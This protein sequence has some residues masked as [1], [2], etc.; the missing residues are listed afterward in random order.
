MELCVELNLHPYIELKTSGY[1]KAEITS[2][3]QLVESCGLLD[4]CTWISFNSTY[5]GYVKAADP[6]ARLGYLRNDDATTTVINTAKG[7]RTDKNEV[8]LDLAYDKLTEAGLL[9]AEENSFA[10]EVW[11]V[12]DENTVKSLPASISGFTSNMLVAEE[13]LK[14]AQVTPPTCTKQGYTT[15][16]CECGESYVDDYVDATGEHTYENGICTVCGTEQSSPVVIT[17]QPTPDDA[18]IGEKATVFV[19]AE[20]EGLTYQWYYR[21]AGETE[22]IKSSVTKSNYTLTVKTTNAGRELYCV[23]TDLYGNQVTTE[24][25][26]LLVHLTEKLAIIQQPV[27]DNAAVGEKATVFVEATGEGLSYQWYYRDAGETEFTK[28][29]VTKSNYTLTVK[30]TNAD[31]E[32]YCVV[33]DLYGNRVTTETVRLLVPLTESLA[34]MKQPVPDDALIGEKATVYVEATGSGLTYQ[35]YYRDAGET[36]FTKST[37]TKSNYTLT[38]KELNLER[39][40][41][42]VITDAFG[43]Q[44]TTDTVRLLVPGNERLSIVTQPIPTRASIGEKATVSVVATGIGLNYQW[45]YRDAGQTEF[46]KSTVTKSVYTLTVKESNIDR[47]LYCVISDADG[48][49]ITTDLIRLLAPVEEPLAIITQPASTHAALG[50]KATVFV[51]ATGDG[52]TY[53]W[54]YRDACNVAFTKST[55]TTNVYTLTVKTSNVSREL[56]CV[57]TDGRGNKLVTDTVNLLLPLAEELA[58]VTQPVP[59]D[60]TVG[61]K[62]KIFVEARG[63]DLSYQWYYR[64]VGSNEFRKSTIVESSYV[65]TVKEANKGR[66]LYCVITDAH[67][68]KVQT[69]TIPL[70]QPGKLYYSSLSD[71]LNQTSGSIDSTDAV[72]EVASENGK[73]VITLLQNTVLTETLSITADLELNLNGYTVSSSV[74]PMICVESGYCTIRNGNITLTSDGTGTASAPA[75]AITVNSGATLDASKT[76]VT[77]TDAANST[78][79]GIAAEAD[80]TLI[81]TQTNVAVTTGKSL[82]NV[83]V[84]AKGTA[85]LTDCSVI[86]ESD[87]TGANGKYTSQSKGVFAEADLE[88]YNCYVWGA[89]SGVCALGNVY[90]DGGT[91]EGY[92]HGSFYFAGSNTTSYVYNAS[93]N[94][95]EMREGT[96][97]DTVAGTNGAGMY[98]GGGA[99]NVSIYMDNCQ[100]YGTLYGIVLRNSGGEKNNSIYISNSTFSGCQSY[101]YRNGHNANNG[102]LR[103]YAGVGNDY[104]AITGKISKFTNY[105]YETDESYAQI[106]AVKDASVMPSATVNIGDLVSYTLTI[107]NNGKQARTVAV[108]DVLPENSTYISGAVSVEGRSIQWNDVIIPAGESIAL[109]YTVQVNNDTS[110]YTEGLLSAESA[111]VD[112]VEVPSYPIYIRRTLTANDAQYLKQAMLALNDSGYTAQTLLKWIY[113]VAYSKSPLITEDPLSTLHTLYSQLD[114]TN[115]ALR[116]TVAPTLYG[117]TAVAD[118]ADSYFAGARATNVRVEDFITGDVL[119]CE[120]DNTGRIYLY[121]EGFVEL[122]NGM[123][124]VDTNSVLE[125]ANSS[126][127]YVVIRP[128][129]AFPTVSV[130]DGMTDSASLSAA[131]KA[132]FVTAQNYLLRGE[133]IQYDDSRL[134]S[135]SGAEFRWKKGAVAPENYTRDEWGYTNCAAFCHDLYGYGIGLNLGSYTTSGLIGKTGWRKYY[136]EVPG[137][138]SSAAAAEQ[139]EKFVSTLQFGDLIIVRRDK[140]GNGSDDSGHVMFYIG[141]GRVIHSTGASYSYT[142]SVETYEPSIRYMDVFDYLFT[143]D[144][145]NYVFDTTV[146]KLAIIRPLSSYNG[147]LPEESQ[148]R[149]NGLSGLR[150]EKLSSC[151]PSVSVNPGDEITFTFEILNANACAKTITITDLL[152]EN[153][154]FVSMIGG[155]CSNGSLFFSVV[156]EAYQTTSV[157]YTVKVKEGSYAKDAK[158]SSDSAKANGVSLACQGISIRNTLTADEQARIKEAIAYYRASNSDELTGIPLINAIYLRAGLEAPFDDEETF[159]NVA[160]GVVEKYTSKAVRIAENGSYRPMLVDGLYGGRYLYTAELAFLSGGDRVR[161]PREQ[162]LVPGDIILGKTSTSE[163]FYIYDGEYI[164]GITTTE[165]KPEDPGYRLERLMAFQHY[166][167]ILRPSFCMG[168]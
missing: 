103:V 112:R 48:N 44:V 137:T 15:Y 113:Q 80:S 142:T 58:I 92:G 52:L 154:E 155:S 90:V 3:V 74:F 18:V 158:V 95:A 96:Y 138:V 81:L 139:K 141:D 43:N 97:A 40:L 82:G 65:L 79:I 5:L 166:F 1:T 115:E 132:L 151:K 57:I 24:T 109:S 136:Y 46:T 16:T 11:T 4:N 22:F 161:L 37:V 66:E 167:V 153:T 160:N 114:D 156:V 61:E 116:N 120:K 119:L 50:E 49:Q 110:L 105:Y 20:G 140:D 35:W 14:N 157:S 72:A 87:Y 45:Y 145:A 111:T 101:A 63:V 91:Y 33:T 21:D 30:G 121:F 147:K 13:I 100:V 26:S 164:Y 25:V 107:T 86:A 59:D 122:T 42:C 165:F 34:I 32:L 168:D 163:L 94:W 89:H 31:R 47:E 162:N 124:Q 133:R 39:V 159:S 77:V 125:L 41:Y 93:V 67:G 53:Q 8:F 134:S 126:D 135:V 76:T 54:Y 128:S 83:G 10:V 70:L 123:K 28:S 98:V 69:Q 75:V 51:E 146:S 152:P 55:V 148:N 23:V 149:T 17:K 129:I 71:A 2:L 29:S 85:I 7:L 12:D 84:H 104:S 73:T 144:S 38:V 131:Q 36:E 88:L 6:T 62:A 19:E 130:S 127:R 106:V 60:V 9:R 150:V 64:D 118:D 78:V 99:K 56:Y 27:P 117:G 143:P 68:N 108:A 102:T